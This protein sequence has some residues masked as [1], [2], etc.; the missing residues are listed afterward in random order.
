MTAI[1]DNEYGDWMSKK[2]ILKG[3]KPDNHYKF[4]KSIQG[5]PEIE[6]DIKQKNKA[7]ENIRKDPIKFIMN[8]LS[9]IGRLLLNYPYS[10]TK[11]KLTTFFYIL[12]NM[13]LIVLLILII[14][15]TIL[16]IKYFPHEIIFSIIFFTIYFFGQ[17]L[18]SAEVRH[19]SIVVPI[20]FLWIVFVIN[21][22]IQIKIT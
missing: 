17:S 12:P 15:P 16:K 3:K 11:Q 20:L 10:Y 19:F 6:K 5:L 18:L 8:W 22:Y 14:Y 1:S 7:I 13:F 9:N 21:N 2:K 4:F